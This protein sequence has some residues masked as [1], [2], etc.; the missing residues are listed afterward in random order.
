MNIEYLEN[1]INDH[2]KRL[3]II[4][5]NTT[6]MKYELLNITKSQTDIKSLVLETNK[7]LSETL[8]NMA[9]TIKENVITNNQI[10]LIDRKELWGILALVVGG[11][12]GYF[13]M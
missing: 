1:R 7:E 10:R 4:E 9:K 3:R 11:V 8:N 5:E 6:E 12:I 2:E 13:V